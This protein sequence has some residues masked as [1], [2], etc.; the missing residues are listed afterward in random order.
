M[1]FRGQADI[2]FLEKSLR[3]VNYLF[4]RGEPAI[5]PTGRRGNAMPT[6]VLRV[7]G[8]SDLRAA[9]RF[10]TQAGR[11]QHAD[12]I[13]AMIEAWTM[14]HTKR[15][16]MEAFGKAGIPAGETFDSLELL[17]DP[18]LKAREMIVTVE[19]PVRGA[20]PM[21]GS[22]IQMSA[23]PRTCTAAPLRVN[24]QKKC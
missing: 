11:N 10:A 2:G 20:F 13:Y 23:S 6:A 14:R 21:P 5:K 18:H 15:A 16:A 3:I 4:L 7:I 12:E 9:P 8:R 17:P 24:T 22:P 1:P 19:H